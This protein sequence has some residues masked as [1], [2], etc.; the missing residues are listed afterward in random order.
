MELEVKDETG[1]HG[2]PERYSTGGI[3]VDSTCHWIDTKTCV[4][5][6]GLLFYDG[7]KAVRLSLV[8]LSCQQDQ[9]V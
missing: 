8:M 1:A 9:G 6:F 7:G 3:R 2:C 5:E 4:S